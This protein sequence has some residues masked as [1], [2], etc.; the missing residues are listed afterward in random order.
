MHTWQSFSVNQLPI[1]EQNDSFSCGAFAF[2]AVEAY[3][4]PFEV[5]LLRSRE[6]A[7]L[8]LQMVTKVIDI[9][10]RMGTDDSASSSSEPSEVSDLEFEDNTLSSPSRKQS[11]AH[12]SAPTPNPSPKKH[13]H[14]HDSLAK[15]S[16]PPLK[17]S[18][19]LESSGSEYED[20]H[21]SSDSEL[22]SSPSSSCLTSLTS[23]KQPPPAD[24]ENAEPRTM[25]QGSLD[26][27]MKKMTPAQLEEQR[28]RGF[29]ELQNVGMREEM[30]KEND[31][32]VKKIR[33]RELVA[34]RQKEWRDRQR[35]KKRAAGEPTD[36]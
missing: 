9:C 28:K 5:E 32:M 8:R 19:A 7:C 23:P 17:L 4:R 26:M 6:A 36:R 22:P 31:K 1:T 14:P 27:F 29:E 16:L 3:V 15:I 11:I 2:N 33:E 30:K 20:T 10:K 24:V 34:K 25:K 12:P 35:E 21:N 18:P 13:K